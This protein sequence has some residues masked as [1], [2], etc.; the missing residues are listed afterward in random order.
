[1]AGAEKPGILDAHNI[2]RDTSAFGED[3]TEQFF[4]SDGLTRLGTWLTAQGSSLP[5][6]AEHERWAS[7]IARPSK[8]I[9]VGL[10]YR[11]HAAET[12]AAIPAEPILFG[13][14]TSSLVGPYDDL[15][16]P[17]GSKKCDWEVELAIIV[18]K[19]ATLVSE[20]DA[21]SYVAGY[22][23]HN[24]YSERAY[25]MERGGQWIK[26]KSWDTFAPLGPWL[27]TRDEIADPQA[28]AMWLTVNG[29]RVQHSST[30]QLIFGVAHLVSYIS[31]FMTLLPGDVISTG[32]P[33]GV[34]LGFKP[35]RY[36]AHGDVVELGV[37]GLGTSKQ[38]AV[39]WARRHES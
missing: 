19:R 31:H 4:D 12:G 25:Q 33:A 3:W 27:A 11:D 16:I 35:P 14:A 13:K 23:L 18:G 7:C 28:L 26:G 8:I 20:S 21:M 5:A 36:L 17:P 6:V 37:E 15:H 39:D 30:A 2:R 10:N 24:D 22:A 38:R 9:C 29:E 34:G 1:M 32:T